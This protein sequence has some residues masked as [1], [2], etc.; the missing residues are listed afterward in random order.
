[1]FYSPKA[2]LLPTP[3]TPQIHSPNPEDYVKCSYYPIPVQAVNIIESFN[4]RCQPT[5]DI[6]VATKYVK[7]KAE[8]DLCGQVY[9][10]VNVDVF[11]KSV[12]SSLATYN[13]D[14]PSWNTSFT[15]KKLCLKLE[16]K[17]SS[18]QSRI[19]IS[20]SPIYNQNSTDFAFNSST[21]SPS[22][23]ST[24]YRRHNQS[25][26][27]D[28][29]Y[30][31]A[32][33]FDSHKES[34]IHSRRAYNENIANF[35]NNSPVPCTKL[36]NSPR[37]SV[38]RQDLYRPQSVDTVKI[39]AKASITPKS[40]NTS[41]NILSPKA[42]QVNN[43]PQCNNNQHSLE[44]I[45]QSHASDVKP[46]LSAIHEKSDEEE[47]YSDPDYEPA[48]DFNPSTNSFGLSPKKLSFSNGYLSDAI[49]AEFMNLNGTCRLCHDTIPSYLAQLHVIECPKSDLD[50]VEEFYKTCA[51]DLQTNKEKIQTYVKDHLQYKFNDD[52]IPNDTFKNC[53]QFYNFCSNVDE[54]EKSQTRRFFEKCGTPP[55]KVTNIL[56]YEHLA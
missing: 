4:I 34:P 23:F 39:K 29:G 11:P 12:L 6:N 32:N 9:T 54:L 20:N 3:N 44:S 27:A 38:N 25:Y 16:W 18:Q 49:D 28:S 31:S 35:P 45:Q 2:G 1:M 55:S 37:K 21:N 41:G 26:Q 51:A 17:V 56:S 50:P 33:R 52:Q 13:L 47:L 8:W 5:W 42:D 24:P 40:E 48:T 10:S 43:S 36:F 30:K 15:G 7:F 46:D 53:E 14:Q 22:S 19:N